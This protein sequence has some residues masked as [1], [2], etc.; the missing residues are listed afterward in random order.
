MLK[1]S[2]DQYIARNKVLYKRFLLQL[3]GKAIPAHLQNKT[4]YNGR[5]SAKRREARAIKN[6][7]KTVV[8]KVY[9]KLSK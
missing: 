7:V 1:K 6:K 4:I 2:F 3:A 8:S 5:I 9:K